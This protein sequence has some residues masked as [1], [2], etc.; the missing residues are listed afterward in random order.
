MKHLKYF[1][2]FESKSDILYFFDFDDT[3]VDSPR[4]EELVIQY[5]KEDVNI[6]HLIDKSLGW[7]K[8]D[9][10]DIKIEHGRLYV[11]DPDQKI[12]VKGNWVRKKG[13]VYMTA[14]DK[15]Y[16]TDLSFPHK[17]TTLANL[18]NSVE[19]KAIVTARIITVKDKIESYM[20]KLGLEKP[21]Y[22]LHCYPSRNESGDRV[23]NWKA[24]TIVDI[25]KKTGFK[26]AKFYDDKS[27][28][29]NVVVKRVNMEL[30]DVEFEGIKVKLHEKI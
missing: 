16:Y 12:E 6:K 21:K 24:K 7:I 29:V 2:I 8:K 13:R 15:F 22:G 5:L 1:N 27:K 4:Y 9:E 25:L 28:I 23:A 18:Y 14:P 19:N 26:K 10:K 17:K 30:P 3:I 11:D 20:D